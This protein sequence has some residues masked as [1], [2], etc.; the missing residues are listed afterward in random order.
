MST[1]ETDWLAGASA[2]ASNPGGRPAKGHKGRQRKLC[3]P[4]CGFICY[5][6]AGAVE[7]AGG[8]PSCACGSPLIVPN[9]RDRAVIEWDQLEAEL[10]QLGRE[11]WNDAMREIGSLD[12]VLPRY[13]DRRSG[14]APKRCAWAEGH[15]VKFTS[16]IYCPEHDPAEQASRR[17]AA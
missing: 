15:C 4:E 8:L 5:A 10:S 17:R 2:P 3:C 14:A 1:V 12:L 16:A 7:R 13:A 9:L 6:T 11:R